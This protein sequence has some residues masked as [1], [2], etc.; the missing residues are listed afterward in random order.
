M[1]NQEIWKDI[2]G[3]EGMYKVSNLGRVRSLARYVPKK[4]GTSMYV[5]ER[6]LNSFINK[7]YEYTTLSNGAKQSNLRVHRLVASAFLPNPTNLPDVNHKDENPL[8]NN[9]CNLEWCTKEYNSF[10]GTA[11]ERSRQSQRKK[12]ESLVCLNLDGTIHKI[13]EC[14]IDIVKD[15]FDRR[16]VGRCVKGVAHRHKGFTWKLFNN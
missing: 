3:Y 5:R 12:G 9:V 13:Y 2:D 10:Y 1:E 4:N 15:G 11:H 16:A 6:I 8:N 7:G 14:T